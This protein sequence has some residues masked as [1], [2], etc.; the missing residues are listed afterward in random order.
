MLR[1]VN[2]FCKFGSMERLLSALGTGCALNT[3]GRRIVSFL[4][5]KT[6]T[7]RSKSL[8]SK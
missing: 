5:K 7:K 8:Q 6:L 1:R 4:C 2:P 3:V